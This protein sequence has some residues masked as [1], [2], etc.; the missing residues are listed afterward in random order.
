MRTPTPQEKKRLSLQRDRRNVYGANSKASRK[1]IPLRKRLVN[2]AER[3]AHD[4]GVK[5]SASLV[6][7]DAIDPVP[8]KLRAATHRG[9]RKEPDM[10]L[11]NVLARKAK[12]RRGK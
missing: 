12:L 5:T 1:A 11:G 3:H 8:R 10:P 9:W 6:D 2:R 7:T 4:L